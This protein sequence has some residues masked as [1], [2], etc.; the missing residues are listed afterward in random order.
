MKTK[1]PSP[2]RF[3]TQLVILFLCAVSASAPHG[4]QTLYKS[5]DSD[6]RVVYSDRPPAEGRIEKT[7]TFENLPSSPLPTSTTAYIDQLR[8]AGPLAPPAATATTGV[9]LYSA[10]WCGFC[11]RAK[12]YL[13]AKGI[14]YREF[15]IDSKEGLAAY[16]RAGG[17]K[18]VP[19]LI[20]G[21][22]R[23]QGFT[24]TAYD[25]FFATLR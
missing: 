14:S 6:G 10:A 2:M 8:S 22:R 11:K 18:G 12:A 23:V 9:V 16:A 13:A 3:A 24:P 17:G 4:A 5:V 1:K 19:L 7:I 21:G 20:A 25:A 15:D